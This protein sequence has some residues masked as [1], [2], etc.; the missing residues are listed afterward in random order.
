MRFLKVLQLLELKFI[1]SSS[2]DLVIVGL[3]FSLKVIKY[4]KIPFVELS[5]TL[6]AVSSALKKIGDAALL[7]LRPED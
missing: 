2:M 3:L 5:V 1:N 7:P 4:I 6:A